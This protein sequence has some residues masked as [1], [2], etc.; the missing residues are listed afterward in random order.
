PRLLVFE[1]GDVFFGEQVEQCSQLVD[2]KAHGCDNAVTVWRGTLGPK[3][4][5]G[6]DRWRSWSFTRGFVGAPERARRAQVRS[7]RLRTRRPAPSNL[8]PRTNAGAS[9]HARPGSK[10]APRCTAGRPRVRR[11]G[12]QST[13]ACTLP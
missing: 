2:V 8:S 6:K 9:V 13:C 5:A 1:L 3:A 4:P 12:A 7:Y 10:G 11:R